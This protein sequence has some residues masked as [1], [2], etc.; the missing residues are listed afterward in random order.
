VRAC[1]PT[2]IDENVSTK[3]IKNTI[4]FIYYI[5]GFYNIKIQT[6]GV[7]MAEKK[8]KKLKEL[9][10]LVSELKEI[11]GRHTELVTVYV[12]AGFNLAKSMEQVK[13]EQSTAQN[14]KSKAVRKNVLSALEKI[15]QHLKLYKKTPE[16]GLALF[17]G[18]VSDK[19]GVADIEL[20]SI[21]PP[22]PVKNK[23]YWCGQ[24]FILDSLKD[25]IK[26]KEIYGL[27]VVDKSEAEIG[28]L[29]GK[30][31]ETLKHM[32]SIVP[33]KTKKGGWSQARYARIREGLLNDFL[34]SVGDIA[35]SKFKELENLQ[36]VIIGG[37]GPIKEEFAGGDFLVYDI[38]S[39]VL[40]VV[41]TAYGG[42]YGLREMIE[43]SE[44]LISQSSVMREEKV[45]TVFFNELGKDSG[46]AIY[47]F[48][49]VVEALRE[50]SIETLLLSE[51][52]D[53]V[54]VEFKCPK[55]KFTEEKVLSRGDISGQVCHKCGNGKQKLEV[56][57][58]K[59]V[60]DEII[61]KAEEMS[62]NI[63]DI[64]VDTQKGEQL[65]ELGGIAGILRFKS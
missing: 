62:T 44:D 16:N 4:L 17:C 32:E 45:L 40:G 24:N 21:E 28:L 39:K 43:K 25:M 61:K 11:R 23:I 33:G 48:Y 15:V 20:W 1:A 47:G 31:I 60:T 59:D 53:W 19:E 10:D 65:K 54:K 3:T 38:K 34:K 37:P 8:E 14:I 30:K 9:K 27:I 57:K 56:K 29:K 18:N 12:P 13:Q 36:G 52:F 26:E 7:I 64:S 42:E 58:E 6:Q 22:E 63:E 5:I 50:G 35:T 49:E 41:N 55:C 2:D 46:L 51:G